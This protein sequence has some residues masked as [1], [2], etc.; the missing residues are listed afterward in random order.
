MSRSEDDGPTPTL[1]EL[2]ALA[3]IEQPAPQPISAIDF[4][5]W[6]ASQCVDQMA[7]DM[8]SK[9]TPDEWEELTSELRQTK[10]QQDKTRDLQA[11]PCNKTVCE[12]V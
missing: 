1:A 9:I 4:M 12:T 6:F 8:R 10:E 3:R 5:G 11:L 7:E 2:G